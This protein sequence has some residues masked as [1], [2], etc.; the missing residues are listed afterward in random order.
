M[1]RFDDRAQETDCSVTLP[2]ASWV[3]HLLTLSSLK[4]PQS[5]ASAT[6]AN[7]V[8][9]NELDQVS[10]VVPPLLLVPSLFR[11]ELHGKNP[12]ILQPTS[13]RF[14]CMTEAGWVDTRSNEAIKRTVKG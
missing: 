3:Y 8:G 4:Q 9:R 14:R 6:S 2:F 13:S 10:G 5:A 11:R 12:I 1:L 7:K